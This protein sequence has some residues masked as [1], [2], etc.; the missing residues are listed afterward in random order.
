VD[1]VFG[2]KKCRS[3]GPAW[4]EGPY[5]NI[6]K[7]V[8]VSDKGEKGQGVVGCWAGEERGNDECRMQSE[9]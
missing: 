8:G 4:R 5:S 6:L 1:E 7:N 2:Q 9:E 3:G